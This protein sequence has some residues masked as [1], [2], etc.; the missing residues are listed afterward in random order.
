VPCRNL[1]N[2]LPKALIHAWE[3]GNKLGQE[4]M[5]ERA[6]KACEGPLSDYAEDGSSFAEAIRALK[7][8]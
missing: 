3:C 6:A 1:K 2:D 7:V 5:R 4:R 8:D